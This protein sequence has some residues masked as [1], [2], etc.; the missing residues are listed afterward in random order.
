VAAP[1]REPVPFTGTQATAQRRAQARK[2]ARQEKAAERIGA[3]TEQLAAGVAEASASAEELRRSLEQIAAAAEEA[4]GAA[5]GSQSAIGN[6]AAVFNQARSQAD[7]SQRKTDAVTILLADV[8]A[9]IETTVSSVRANA[10]RQI[11]AVDVVAALESHAA[12]IGD[13]T[14]AVSDIADQTN[15]LALNAAI[16]ASRAG[17]HGR[18]FAVVA[19][20]VRSFAESADKSAREVQSLSATIGDDVRA[21][22][23][24]IQKSAE[25]A[26]VEAENGGTVSATLEDIRGK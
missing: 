9:R 10:T 16:E 1:A 19:D 21:M 25:A 6:L 17:E 20:E 14:T 3:A 13:I 12:N 18:G 26:R 22:A 5:R 7:V 23:A 15:L 11:R 24:R 4:A 8:G 2:R